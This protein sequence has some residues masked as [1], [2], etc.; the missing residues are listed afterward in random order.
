MA[1]FSLGN[2]KV[3]FR[4]PDWFIAPNAT[5]IHSVVLENNASIW[6]HVVVRCDSDVIIIGETSNVQDGSVLHADPG[7][8][9]TL[10]RNA[11]VDIK[12]GN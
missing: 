8:P 5:V 11:S 10:G 12:A 4:G 3:E 9:L 6:L 7:F 2:R 1:Y